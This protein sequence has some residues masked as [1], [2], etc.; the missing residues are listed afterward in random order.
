MYS[1]KF[2]ITNQIL[3]N[4]GGVEASK[5]LIEN[6]PLI[7][8]YEKAFQDE[9]LVKT[10]YHATHLEGGDLTLT[11]A[12]QVLEGTK[13]FARERDVQEVINYRNVIKIIEEQAFATEEKYEEKM[14]RK[15]HK[16]V[17]D[18]V[19]EDEAAGEFRQSQ[20][21]IKD[22]LTGLVTFRPPASVEIPYLLEDFFDWLNS[23]E[24]LRLH[25]LLKAG[26]TH[27]VL[28]AIHPFVE[29]NGRAARA[30]ATLVM[31]KE[32]YDIKRFFALEEHFDK[33]ALSYYQALQSVSDQ[34]PTFEERDLTPWLEYFTG[35]VAIELEKI[36]D[37]V[38]KLSTDKILKDRLGGQ[39]AL[40]ERQVKLMEHLNTNLVLYMK[41]ALKI[42][43][44]VSP[45][46]LLR[47]VMDLTKKGIIKKEGIT[48]NARYVLRRD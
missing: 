5:A 16:A 27:Y 42:L 13:I 28:V 45:D 39:V 29:G 20:V 4:I 19:I 44:R 10:I 37:R 48:K 47:D 2:T 38:K 3:K 35:V 24:A 9:A 41:D 30:F 43:P 34:T 32:G 12:Q 40:S 31:L 33:N 8:A 23:Q 7:P 26:I 15:I 46:T 14:L 22:S 1:P 6:A 25:P 21:V 36:R 11:Q 18:K 17:I